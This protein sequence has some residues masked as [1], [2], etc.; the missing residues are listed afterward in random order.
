[1]LDRLSRSWHM[2]QQ[3]WRVLL[4][5]KSLLLFPI[6]AAVTSVLA[7]A[8]M[9]G[10]I[11]LEIPG[12]VAGAQ[13]TSATGET[14]SWAPSAV[15][16]AL[17]F[18]AAFVATFLSIFFNVAMVCCARRSFRG[19]D[20]TVGE[21]IG[22]AMSRLPQ[23]LGWALVSFLVGVLLNALDA[24]ADEAPP[25]ISI[26]ANVGVWLI[27]LAWSAATFLVIS[28]LAYENVGPIAAV[29]RSTDAVK[30]TWGESLAGN[31]AMG[32]IFFFAGVL[33]AIGLCVFGGSQFEANPALGTLLVGIGVAYGCIA[34]TLSSAINN[35]FRAAVYEYAAT[36]SVPAG[37]SQ[38]EL[39]G[40]FTTK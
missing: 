8:L 17:F 38:R 18:G 24:I 22:A 40:A 39:A 34:M 35:L 16:V 14:T 32:L 30:K 1:M 11:L 15:Q 27:G 5:D 26:I 4:A 6:L 31:M 9:V 19:E 25:P 37:F 12:E 2:I 3:C 28:V 13:P 23:I 7:F 10:P 29:R 36:G 20:T 33:P 21:G